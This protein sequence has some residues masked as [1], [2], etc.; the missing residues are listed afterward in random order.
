MKVNDDNG[1]ESSLMML[2][3][4]EVCQMLRG[5]QKM[6]HSLL[7]SHTAKMWDS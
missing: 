2:P 5:G 3:S 1:M 4:V 7:I 6:R